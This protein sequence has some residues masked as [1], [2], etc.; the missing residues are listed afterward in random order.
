MGV[1]QKA[2]ERS[3]LDHPHLQLLPASLSD[4]GQARDRQ[5]RREPSAQR[6]VNL[7]AHLREA[8]AQPERR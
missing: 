4:S 3:I 5:G 7:V 8:E 1:V 2:P 6:C